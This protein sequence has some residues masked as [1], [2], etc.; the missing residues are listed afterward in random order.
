MSNKSNGTAFEKEFAQ[1]LSDNGFWAHCL[2]DN[3]NGQPFDIIA[4]KNG[5]VYAFDCKDCSG[6]NFKLS[7]MEENQRNAMD[8]WM[9]C[10]NENAMFVTKFPSEKI[11]IFEYKDLV[12]YERDGMSSMAKGEAG[13]Y[14]YTFN[15]FMRM[16]Q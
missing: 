4:A 16:F 12:A 10:G 2:Q 15:E 14:G 5:K 6:N 1:L 9:E 8:L 13:V 11:F 7:R 3:Q